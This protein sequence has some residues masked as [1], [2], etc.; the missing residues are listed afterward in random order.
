MHILASAVPG[1]REI[2]G[3]VI[4]GYIWFLFAWLM[5]APDL[6]TRPDDRIVGALYDLAVLVGPIATA[7]AVSVAAYLVGSVSQA[8]FAPLSGMLTPS[9]D[10]RWGTRVSNDLDH[11]RSRASRLVDQAMGPTAKMSDE[12]LAKSQSLIGQIA[13]RHIQALDELRGRNRAPS[14]SLGGRTAAPIRGCRST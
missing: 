12:A 8:L 5:L 9:R 4:A 3:P 11:L 14:D 1:L 13:D 6:Q 2:R 7:A 10:I